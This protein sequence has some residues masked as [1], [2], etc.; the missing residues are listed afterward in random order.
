M[1]GGNREMANYKLDL[2]LPALSLLLVYSIGQTKP[3]ASGPGPLGVVSVDI[4]LG[5]TE[6]G[7]E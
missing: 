7:Q 3:E 1:D 4:S 2:F 6:L 5:G